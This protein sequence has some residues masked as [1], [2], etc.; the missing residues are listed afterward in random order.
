MPWV[1][2]LTVELVTEIAVFAA[3][4]PSS[5]LGPMMLPERVRP[6]TDDPSVDD[7]PLVIEIQVEA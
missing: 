5:A 6:K 1:P 2:P 4:T 7:A 3:L